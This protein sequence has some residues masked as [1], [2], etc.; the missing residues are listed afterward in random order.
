MTIR[1]ITRKARSGGGGV[2]GAIGNTVI[3]SIAHKEKGRNL[4]TSIRNIPGIGKIGMGVEILQ[5]IGRKENGRQFMTI[6]YNPGSDPINLDSINRKKGAIKT[7]LLER[8][9]RIIINSN[10][11]FLLILMDNDRMPIKRILWMAEFVN[12][13][14]AKTIITYATP[15]PQN[16]ML[17][18]NSFVF[19]LFKYPRTNPD[20][21]PLNPY[22]SETIKP[23]LLLKSN[24][25]IN[26]K[27]KNKTK[28][29]QIIQSDEYVN[30]IR[31][32]D[33]YN[34]AKPVMIKLLN[35]SMVRD[36][37]TSLFN[38]FQRGKTIS[39]IGGITTKKK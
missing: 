21:K 26:N 33:R 24:S 37:S 39:E 23:I 9:P 13:G 30:F 29:M 20:Y 17:G 8:E 28:K 12:R 19:K 4:K 3:H 7:S 6:I 1:K 38:A 31:Y 16:N 5:E 15:L 35:V 11:R 22:S 36:T 27:I 25:H 32:L 18:S 34:L 10:D 14:K 2:L